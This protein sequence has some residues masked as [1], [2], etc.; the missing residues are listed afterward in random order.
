MLKSLSLASS[1]DHVE[2]DLGKEQDRAKQPNHMP[3]IR[4]F[5]MGYKIKPDEDLSGPKGEKLP[6]GKIF[7][8]IQS[9]IYPL[10]EFCRRA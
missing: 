5:E 10:Y 7:I 6:F 3:Y 1:S 4:H 9:I 2:L 8:F